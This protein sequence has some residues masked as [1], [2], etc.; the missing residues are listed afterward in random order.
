MVNILAQKA[1]I[2]NKNTS[3]KILMKAPILE[4]NFK[5]HFI[6]YIFLKNQQ[7]LIYNVPLKMFH[8]LPNF[9]DILKIGIK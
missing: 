9:P 5:L 8:S 7:S 6:W 4:L 1:R 3:L 2:Q